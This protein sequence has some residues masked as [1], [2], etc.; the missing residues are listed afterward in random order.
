MNIQVQLASSFHWPIFALCD[1]LNR[2][3][4]MLKQVVFPWLGMLTRRHKMVTV[5]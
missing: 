2:T 1:L 5:Q 4:R 3:L